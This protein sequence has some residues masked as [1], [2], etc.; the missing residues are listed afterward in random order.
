VYFYLP[1][2]D[3]TLFS[4]KASYKACHIYICYEREMSRINRLERQ[5]EMRVHEQYA[6]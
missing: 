4:Q 3:I 1:L 2:L 5:A 6:R